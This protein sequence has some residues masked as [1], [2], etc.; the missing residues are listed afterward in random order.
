M[1]PP[2]SRLQSLRATVAWLLDLGAVP[3]RLEPQKKKPIG[4][5][6]GTLRPTPEQFGER[7]NIGIKVGAS[8][9][10]VDIDCDWPESRFLA[11]KFLPVTNR[12]HGRPGSRESHY[13][14]RVV[15]DSTCEQHKDPTV[16][17]GKGD[18]AT[19]VEF[20]GGTES[21]QRQTMIPPSIHPSGEVLEWDRHGDPSEVSADDLM[22]AVRRLAAASLLAKHWPGA[23]HEASLALC[24]ALARAG[25]TEQTIADFVT[26][27]ASWV[28]RAEPDIAD[29]QPS[30]RK[31]QARDSIAAV[32]NGDQCTGIPT[33]ISLGV[34]DKVIAKLRTWLDL[35]VAAMADNPEAQSN[36]GPLTELTDAK[37]KRQPIDIARD[38][39][40]SHA[41][42]ADGVLLR[43]WRG[44]WYRWR[45]DRAYYVPQTDDQ[46]DAD[47]YRSARLK[48]RSQVSDVRHALI[49]VD[50]VLVD[51]AELGA[52]LDD[53]AS[54]HDPI[55]LAP[56]RNG[57][58]HLPTRM[59]IPATP[60]YFSTTALGVAY[61]PT[62]PPPRAWLAFLRQLWP[63]DDE[64]IAL[65]QE[66]IA[67]LLTADT[68]Q[69]KIL[70][71]LGPKRSGKGTIARVIAALLGA[72][73][74]ASPTLA[75]LGTNFGLWP[76]IGKTAAII[77]DARLGGRSDIAQVVERLL[78]ISGEDMQT[79]DRKHREPW[80]GKL[81]TRI[82]IISNEP[83]RFSDASDA[84]ASRMLVLQL[85][86]SFFGNED[87][88]LT[89]KLIAE[90]PGILR[91]AIDGWKRLR[92]RGRF[93]QPKSSADMI[94]EL[95]DLASPVAAWARQQCRTDEPD[96]QWWLA[97]SDAYERF[98]LWCDGQ[99]I[100]VAPTMQV[101]GRDVQTAT[102]CKRTQVKRGDRVIWVYRGLAFP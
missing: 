11:P 33:L 8:S 63:K 59:I 83:P 53:R 70:L 73:S 2:I 4:N 54:E 60:N 74:V 34:P 30:K 91:W 66:W 31:A 26:A 27:I 48:K 20:R 84:L 6:W 96:R 81:S 47:L 87:T 80:T 101:F 50:D 15:G 86:N 35:P 37:P 17:A 89:G 12:T 77:G 14:Y 38:Y 51:H 52:W 9:S 25:W 79:I 40:S 58:L 28:N 82:T 67:Y 42:H 97:C 49:A 55:D 78:S 95:I 3:V 36:G 21:D 75:S 19:I 45:T 44:D 62:P 102:G 1:T 46:I 65:L 18:K 61:D 5:A 29:G 90:L 64:S 93:V 16:K 10:L 92:G 24:G 39:V 23:R 100:K 57:I 99:G 41:T 69:Q 71:L 7:E 98:K 43:R 72:A 76:L 85:E 22:V 94:G 32:K 68:R 13:W 56:C 88:G